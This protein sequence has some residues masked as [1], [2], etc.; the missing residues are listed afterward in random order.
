MPVWAQGLY[1]CLIAFTVPFYCLIGFGWI[2]PAGVFAMFQLVAVLML[3][4]LYWNRAKYGRR[5]LYRMMAMLLLS[6]LML[7]GFAASFYY[8]L[9]VRG[10]DGVLGQSI[11]A[12]AGTAWIGGWVAFI[13]KVFPGGGTITAS[14]YQSYDWEEFDRQYRAA[15][16]K[17]LADLEADPRLRQYIP[18]VENNLIFSID[19]ALYLEDPT[20]TVTCPHLREI[21]AAMR[22]AGVSVR[23]TSSRMGEASPLYVFANA[24]LSEQALR[25]R[26]HVPWGVAYSEYYNEWEDRGPGSDARLYCKDCHSSIQMHHPQERQPTTKD[27]PV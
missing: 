21:E 1:T 14:G 4:L 3:P 5:D 22:G 25:A 27:F 18:D 26:F 10:Q 11:A 7:A 2:T 16:A 23:R 17:L 6:P 8:M 13:L 15:K 24:V 19:E 12:I 9:E 20:Q